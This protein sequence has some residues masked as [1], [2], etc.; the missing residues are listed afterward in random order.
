MRGHYTIIMVR[1]GDQEAVE[2]AARKFRAQAGEALCALA[3]T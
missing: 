2:P 3:G 1:G